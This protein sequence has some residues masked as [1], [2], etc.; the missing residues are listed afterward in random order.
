MSYNTIIMFLFFHS[1]LG[2]SQH[3]S[4]RITSCVLYELF[5]FVCFLFFLLWFFRFFAIE[6]NDKSDSGQS[7]GVCVVVGYWI[8]VSVTVKD[9]LPRSDLHICWVLEGRRKQSATK[10]TRLV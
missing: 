5:V 6:A 3:I 8:C 7:D 9:L 2:M 10:R 1:V 4:G